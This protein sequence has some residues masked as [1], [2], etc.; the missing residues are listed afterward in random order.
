MTTKRRKVL[1]I[2]L[3]IAV[4]FSASWFLA[5]PV[6]NFFY[7]LF[8]PVQRGFSEVGDNFELL[9]RIANLELVLGEN[10]AL[11]QALGAGL[12]K[13]F[14]LELSEFVSQ[15]S[16]QDVFFIN[17]GKDE[18]LAEGMPVISSEGVLVGRI[19]ETWAD[20]SRVSLISADGFV[21]DI[22]I[23]NS[24]G[25]ALGAGRGQ[26]KSQIALE[27]VPK[28]KEAIKGDLVITSALGGN[29]P[30]GLL[31]GEVKE[32]IKTDAEPFQKGS[33]KPFFT[34]S[35]LSYLFVITNFEP[36][37]AE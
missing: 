24:S 20:F 37:E 8:S 21:F 16:G 15:V 18:G 33:I 7:N 3:I 22:E 25:D 29:F 13:E 1:V 12:D 5:S 27:L 9:Q 11:K 2:V 31:V 36:L 14:T 17:S 30:K 10:L 23:K 32:I 6:K 28:D 34:Q 19:I 35:D 26:G 4:L